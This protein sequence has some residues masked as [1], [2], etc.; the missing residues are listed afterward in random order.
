LYELLRLASIPL[1]TPSPT[2]GFHSSYY[3]GL[4][5]GLAEVIWGIVQGYEQLSLYE[6][7]MKPE[8][9]T[10]STEAEVVKE[11]TQAGTENA[12]DELTPQVGLLNSEFS[13]DADPNAD[14]E[15]EDEAELERKVEILERMR[16]RRGG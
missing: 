11:D 8:P 10:R 16:E 12:Q 2:S 1:V 3:L 5:W 9:R 6:D 7:V 4:G 13:M 14:R 15:R